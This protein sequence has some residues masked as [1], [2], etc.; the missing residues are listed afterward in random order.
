[1]KTNVYISKSR[2]KDYIETWN[3]SHKLLASSPLPRQTAG[4][5]GHPG[6]NLLMEIELKYKYV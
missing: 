1:M 5:T 6:D 4:P 3:G 2:L